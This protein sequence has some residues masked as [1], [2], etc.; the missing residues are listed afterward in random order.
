MDFVAEKRANL[1][2]KQAAVAYSQQYCLEV[3]RSLV[4][5]N[6]AELKKAL[7]L[8]RIPKSVTKS[9]TTLELPCEYRPGETETVYVFK[10]PTHPGR[11]LLAK[12]SLS[13]GL[14]ESHL[15]EKGHLWQNQALRVFES[16][17]STKMSAT[18]SA[19]LKEKFQYLSGLGEFLERHGFKEGDEEKD[20]DEEEQDAPA[21]AIQIDDDDEDLEDDHDMIPSAPVSMLERKRSFSSSRGS[22]KHGRS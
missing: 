11:E 7:R 17:T 5:M 13:Q 14:S 8:K 20:S 10:D 1:P 9:L 21:E 22:I 3:R 12:Q 19:M 16:S 15:E 6:A 18:G 4:V 2:F